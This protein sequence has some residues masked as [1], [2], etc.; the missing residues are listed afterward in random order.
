MAAGFGLFVS[1]EAL[2]VW[3]GGALGRSLALDGVAASS[4]LGGA[5]VPYLAATVLWVY[6]GV[7]ISD[8]VPYFAGRLAASKGEL[9]RNKLGI[10]DTKKLDKVVATVKRYGN[11]IGFVERFSLG[12][13]NPTAFLAGAALSIG[14]ALKERPIA[15]LA[16]VAAVVGTWTIFPY[17]AALIASLVYFKDQD[18]E[19]DAA[20][21]LRGL[22]LILIHNSHLTAS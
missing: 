19:Q 4:L 12:V 17:A 11:Y 14:Y 6:W 15:A 9:V 1:E 13:R 16:T 22:H 5:H 18:K 20:P 10:R 8:L 3:V 7:C 21:L 2:N